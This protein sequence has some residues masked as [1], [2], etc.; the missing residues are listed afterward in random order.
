MPNLVTAGNSCFEN[1]T[2]TTGFSFPKLDEAGNACFRG[3]TSVT[4][5]DVFSVL[6]VSPNGTVGI[7]CFQNCVS[8][9]SFHFVYAQSCG[10][11][12]FKGCTGATTIQLDNCQTVGIIVFTPVPQRPRLILFRLLPAVLQRVMITFLRLAH[13]RDLQSI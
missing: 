11:N 12:C 4:A 10:D 6:A 3:C 8:C 2:S 1:C 13:F 9:T 7:S 5:F